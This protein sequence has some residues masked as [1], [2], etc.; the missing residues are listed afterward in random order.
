MSS[1]I[2]IQQMAV[3][4]ILVAIGWGL[5][6]AGI[7]DGITRKH[8]SFIV[9][10]LTNP[11]L[12]LTTA[13][14][15]DVRLSHRDF[16]IALAVAGVFYIFLILLGRLLPRILPIRPDE[17]KFYDMMIV[18]TNIGFIGIP[19]ASAVLPDG[20]MVYVVICNIMFFLFFYTHGIR[21][22]REERGGFSV[23][24]L[25]NPGTIASVIT[26]LLFWFGL[27]LPLFLNTTIS[28]IGNATLFLS[29]TM[30]GASLARADIPG[31]LKRP[32]IWCYVVIRMI[33]VPL[34]LFFIL[35]A[36]KLPVGMIEAFAL[37]AMVP[38]GNLPMVQAEADGLPTATLSEGIVGST[39]LCFFTITL[40]MSL[41]F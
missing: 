33:A 36:L 11:C 18:Y 7:L 29:L 9:V 20:A 32:G 25:I 12:I 39:I 4:A 8:M 22:L 37:M 21:T 34:A 41:L 13:I 6:R 28:Y 14:T 38:A 1:L 35:K 26:V 17:R 40:L 27:K 19:I 31:S 23:K 24:K 16:L 2:I 15:S 10:N 3:I 30:L 5:Q